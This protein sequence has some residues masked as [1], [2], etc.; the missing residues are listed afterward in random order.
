M[1]MVVAIEECPNSVLTTSIRVL[2][3]NSLV[4]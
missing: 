3:R 2:F 4:A 1:S